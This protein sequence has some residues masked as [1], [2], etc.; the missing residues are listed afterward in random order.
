MLRDI[1]RSNTSI[2]FTIKWKMFDEID[3]IDLHILSRKYS[4]INFDYKCESILLAEGPKYDSEIIEFFI[5]EGADTCRELDMLIL[6]NAMCMDLCNDGI[7]VYMDDYNKEPYKFT[8]GFIQEG[9]NFVVE[10]KIIGSPLSLALLQ[11][12]YYESNIDIIENYLNPTLTKS[13]RNV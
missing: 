1:I 9:W 5:C 8:D 4:T 7:E 12:G 11:L 10:N 2:E 6:A 13:A 3:F